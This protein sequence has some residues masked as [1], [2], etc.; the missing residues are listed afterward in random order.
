MKFI[1][2][3][4]QRDDAEKF[5][6]GFSCQ[7]WKKTASQFIDYYI[8]QLSGKRIIFVAEFEGDVLG[9]VTLLNHAEDGPFVGMQIPEI[10]DFNVLAAYQK[11]GIGTSLLDSAEN[12]ARKKSDKVCLGVGLHA[13]YG[14][15][16]KMYVKRGYI[17]D[18][19]GIWYRNRRLAE[20]AATVNDDNLTLYMIKQLKGK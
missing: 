2:R 15:A 17:P 12:E 18:G 3:Y 14:E 20:G 5:E 7:G 1:I 4:L 13:G 8:E 10:K 16:Q 6:Y 19:S 9:Y 11:N